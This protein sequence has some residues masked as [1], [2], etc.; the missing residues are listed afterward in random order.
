MAN[1]EKIEYAQ[2]SE[3]ELNTR[4]AEFREK[5]FQLK[6]QNATAQIK[7]PH[8]I[9]AAKKE[10]ARCLTFLNQ[11]ELKKKKAGKTSAAAKA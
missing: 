7:N 1:K 2:L 3:D 8:E 10:V 4:L 6:F 11:L 5:A 9:S